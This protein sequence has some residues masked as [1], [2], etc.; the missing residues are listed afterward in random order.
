MNFLVDAQLPRRLARFLQSQGYDAIHTRD[1]P[2]GN[3]TSDDDINTISIQ[4]QRVVISKDA[5][6]IQSFIL[7]Q[8]PYKLLSVATGNIKNADLEE[9]FQQNLSQLVELF[10]THSYIE[11]GRDAIIIHQ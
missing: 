11:L 4:E 9:L 3:A 2:E 5:D 7:Q 10:A 8:K 6:F 1:L